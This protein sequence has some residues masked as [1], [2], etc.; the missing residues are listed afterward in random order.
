M[1]ALGDSLSKLVRVPMLSA[2]LAL[3]RGPARMAGLGSLQ[4][5]LERGFSAF[6]R[7]KKPGDFVAAISSRERAIM[8]RIY[9]GHAAPF[10]LPG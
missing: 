1:Q 5:F 4:Q 2:T 7:M 8:D 9:G 10:D 3:M 6:K